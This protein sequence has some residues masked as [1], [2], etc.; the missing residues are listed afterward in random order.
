MQGGLFERL[1]DVLYP[2][3]AVC[4]ACGREAA[5]DARGLCAECGPKARPC[6]EVPLPVGLD[7]AFAGLYYA[8]ALQGALYR[9]KYGEEQYLAGCL[10]AFLQL[11]A[12]CVPD[13][14]APVPLHPARQRERGFNQSELLARQLSGR[15]GIP[16]EPGLLR[17]VKQTL[18]QASLKG[19]ERAG[20]VQAAFSAENAEG[21]TIL[22]IDDLLTSGNTLTACALALRAAG[23]KKVYAACVFAAG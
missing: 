4:F 5:L 3:D 23:A 10:A 12:G 2:P 11:P 17:R 6:G 1:L 15:V 8:E 20:N 9:F 19:A 21:R 14:L 18:P 22:L 16:V 7:G 13:A